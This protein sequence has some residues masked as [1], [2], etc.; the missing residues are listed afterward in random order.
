MCGIAGI[1]NSSGLGSQERHLLQRMCDVIV[2]RG[3]DDEGFHFAGRAGIGIRRLSIIDLTTGHQ[4]IANEDGSLHAVLNG[5]IYNYR[6]I[7]KDL[8]ARGH[9]LTTQSDTETIVHLYEEYG[10]DCVRHLRGMFCF[11]LW[12]ERRQRLLVARDR[13]GIKQLYYAQPNGTL[14]FGSEIKCLLQSPDV[15]R[16]IRPRS[17]AAYLTF[18]YVPA[19]ET[20]YEGVE[21]L[22]PAH[23]L[24]WEEGRV[25]TWRYWQLE[26]RVADGRPEAEYVEGLEAKLADAVS[27]HLVSDVPLGAFLSGGIDSGTIVALMSRASQGPVE[28]FTVGFEGDYGY[29]DERKEARLVA[30]RYGTRHEEFLVRPQ[31]HEILPHIVTSLDQP[32]ADSSAVPNYYISKLARTRV[33]V[34]LS[35]MGGDE[36]TGGYERYLGVLLGDRYRLMPAPLRRALAR[37][38]R[39]LPDFGGRGRF[40]AARMKRFVRSAEMDP[41]RAYLQL[42]STFDPMELRRLLTGEWREE[43]EHFAPEEWV[44]R[45]FRE[46][47]SDQAVHQMLF[48]DLTGYLPGDLLPL[49]DRMSMAHSLEVRVPLLD[50]ELLEYVATIPA[51]LKIRRGTKKYILRRVAEKLLPEELMRREKR[52]F[53]IPLAFWLRNE[54]AP[55]VRELLGR[56]RLARVGIFNPDEVARLVEEHFAER[57][58]HE[59]KIWALLIFAVWF[60]IVHAPDPA[61][62]VAAPA[63]RL[64]P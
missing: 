35:G 40:S 49:T 1:A 22:P 62:T 10:D 61:A 45:A 53:S 28:T 50:H 23:C 29:Y 14:L 34:A 18:L 56:E 43:L 13:V 42:I 54:L 39:G 19:P 36:L 38:V 2:H 37:A 59:N 20:I 51:G 6:E 55:L 25:R 58:N 21:E 26:Y 63:T 8:L 52:G 7:R 12:D 31:V 15:R 5:E 4:P 33:T 11:A 46:S 17:V 44:L 3:P 48:A 60:D 64:G 24:A 41:P 16:R 27:S 32:L 57:A 30:E 9:R 47:E